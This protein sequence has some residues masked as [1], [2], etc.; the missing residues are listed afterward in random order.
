MAGLEEWSQW[1]ESIPLARPFAL[2]PLAGGQNNRAYRLSTPESNY[3]LKHYSDTVRLHTEFEFLQRLGGLT[4]VP[5]PLAMNPDLRVALFEY[6]QGRPASPE[7]VEEG[8]PEAV[9]LLEAIQFHRDGSPRAASDAC[10]NPREHLAKVEGRV[11]AC[12]DELAGIPE[13]ASFI[14]GELRPRWERQRR[15]TP[16]NPGSTILSPSDFGFHNALR[17]PSGQFC[18]I[19]FEYAGLDDP[20]KAICDFYA[21]PRLPV[22]VS[23]LPQFAPFLT[24][25]VV[26]RIHWLWPLTLIKWTCIL[27]NPFLQ[28]TAD[29]KRFAQGSVDPLAQ[30]AQARLLLERQE[31]FLDQLKGEARGR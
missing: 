16:P 25:P 27:M 18:F 24:A 10:I 11:K 15:V 28:A 23:T 9:A 7:D 29:R 17:R 8:V 1:L 13:L 22:P 4:S 2:E 21:Q 12:L 5:Q 19:D 30:V 6:I 3:C 26:A 31:A 14:L 20:A